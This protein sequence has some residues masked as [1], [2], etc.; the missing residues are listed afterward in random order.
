MSAPDREGGSLR[1][2]AGSGL[3]KVF[4]SPRLGPR[5]TSRCP[6]TSIP[7]RLERCQVLLETAR[8]DLLDVAAVR[9]SITMIA[10]FLST[11]PIL[12][13]L[14]ADRSGRGTSAS[15]R[16]LKRQPDARHSSLPALPSCVVFEELPYRLFRELVFENRLKWASGSGSGLVRKRRFEDAFYFARSRSVPCDFHGIVF[17]GASCRCAV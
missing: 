17:D 8:H 5:G 11:A 9:L 10:A 13:R 14:V 1:S 7:A 3:A 16:A 15:G 12:R 6:T 2:S 4:A